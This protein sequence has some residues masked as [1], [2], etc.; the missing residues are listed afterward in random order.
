METKPKQSP[1]A[2]SIEDKLQ[3]NRVLRDVRREMGKFKLDSTKIT[4]SIRRGTLSVFGKFAPLSG[5][6]A[7]FDDERKALLKALG[8]LPE[9]H[10]VV[11]QR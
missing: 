4:L 9:V 5:H 10:Q 3:N 6:E 8:N 1:A 2:K 7:L 11:C